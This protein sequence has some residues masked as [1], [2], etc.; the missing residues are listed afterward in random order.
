[1]LESLLGFF[2]KKL[3]RFVCITLLLDWMQSS[4]SLRIPRP[5]K[6]PE[7]V[8]LLGDIDWAS[9]MDRSNIMQIERNKDFPITIYRINSISV[10]ILCMSTIKTYNS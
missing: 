4:P 9:G 1:M 10:D 5:M 3:V 6:H 2:W 8:R 7:N